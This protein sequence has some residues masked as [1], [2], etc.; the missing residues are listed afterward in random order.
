MYFLAYYSFSRPSCSLCFLLFQPESLTAAEAAASWLLL[1]V[2]AQQ[3]RF[4]L[5]SAKWTSHPNLSTISGVLE[6]NNQR[7]IE[8]KK[9]PQ[10]QLHSLSWIGEFFSFSRLSDP[11]KDWIFKLPIS[12]DCVEVRHPSCKGR[13]FC[14]LSSS[15]SALTFEK[16]MGWNRSESFL[17]HHYANLLKDCFFVLPI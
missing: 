1:S 12:L 4:L 3:Q 15:F 17:L 2:A 6:A 16:A 11:P 8:G 13:V 10:A 9:N 5:Q 14:Y 7:P